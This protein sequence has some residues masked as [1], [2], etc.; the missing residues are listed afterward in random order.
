MPRIKKTKN[1]PYG[2]S[3][4]QRLVINEAIETVKQGNKLNLTKITAKYYDTKYPNRLSHQN[5]K[6]IDFRQALLRGL[7]NKR[8]IGKDSKVEAKLEEGLDAVRIGRDGIPLPLYDTRLRY[9]QEI[10]KIAGTYAPTTTTNKRL[11][12]NLE[13]TPDELEANIQKLQKQLGS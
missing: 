6:S 9:I 8:I 7:T 11:N 10:N 4:K 2:L 1:N 5:T 13:I 3:T 12:L